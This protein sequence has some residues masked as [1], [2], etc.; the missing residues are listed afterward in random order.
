MSKGF[1]FSLRQIEQVISHMVI[2]FRLTEK[3]APLFP[4]ILSFLL[5]IRRYDINIYKQ[6][7]DAEFESTKLI[8]DLKLE[9]YIEEFYIKDITVHFELYLKEK[10]QNYEPKISA[11]DRK[12][13]PFFYSY[14]GI[15]VAIK[16]IEL[17][18][19]FTSF[20][21]PITV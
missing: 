13:S 20:H 2:V 12:G 10:K 16:K 17:L 9:E 1:K 7:V 18:K 19:R 4:T 8:T 14:G 5:T 6:I 21:S 11:E 15:S 3:N